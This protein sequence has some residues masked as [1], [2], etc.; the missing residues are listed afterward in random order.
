MTILS[1][2]PGLTVPFR[3]QPSDESLGYSL[4][5]LPGL[6]GRGKSRFFRTLPQLLDF[7]SKV[8]AFPA[9]GSFPTQAGMATEADK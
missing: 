9:F 5:P 2:L 7:F 8:V 6:G 3:S 1:S 4:P